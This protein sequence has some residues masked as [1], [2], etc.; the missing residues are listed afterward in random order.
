MSG[1]V[2]NSELEEKLKVFKEKNVRLGFANHTKGK[3]NWGKD[4]VKP[5][6]KC[7]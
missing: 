1:K 7:Y 2:S 5:E 6:L 3:E 4:P